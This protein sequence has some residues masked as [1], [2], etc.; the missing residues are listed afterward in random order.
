ML[1]DKAKF[2]TAYSFE[3]VSLRTKHVRNKLKNWVELK[4]QHKSIQN[5]ILNARINFALKCANRNMQKHSSENFIVAVKES[6]KDTRSELSD[7]NFSDEFYSNLRRFLIED[8]A[9]N[10]S[11]VIEQPPNVG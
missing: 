6:I 4:K 9:T 10:S 5:G 8:H 7:F 3:S 1:I 2:V 11:V